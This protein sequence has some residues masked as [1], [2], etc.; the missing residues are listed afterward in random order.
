M[1]AFAKEDF[2]LSTIHLDDFQPE[3]PLILNIPTIQKLLLSF[4]LM[5]T[6]FVGIS[7]RC[8]I[9]SFI[10]SGESKLCP[11]NI[12]LLLEQ[13]NSVPLMLQIIF[14]ITALNLN[15]PL[16]KFLGKIIFYVYLCT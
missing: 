5:V 8:F 14:S 7:S 16:S 1:T 13:V 3:L 12:L 10:G 6:L 2:S 15:S 11:I 4:I 9:I